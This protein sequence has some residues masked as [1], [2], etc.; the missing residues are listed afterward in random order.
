MI[1]NE[2]ENSLFYIKER[3]MKKKRVKYLAILE[4]ILYVNYK[5]ER[6]VF[7]KKMK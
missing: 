5:T 2:G 6:I 1:Q 4:T 3:I 7:F